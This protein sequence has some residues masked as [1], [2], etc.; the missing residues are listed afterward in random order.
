MPDDVFPLNLALE[1]VKL[2]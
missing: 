2:S 1:F